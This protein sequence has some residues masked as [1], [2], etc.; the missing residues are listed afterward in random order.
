MAGVVDT[1]LRHFQHNDFNYTLNP[2]PLGDESIDDFLFKT[3]KGY[4]EHYA[5]AFAVLMRTAGMP[6]RV[7]TG[8]QG[9]SANPVDGYWVVRQADAHAWVEVWLSERG[10][11]RVDPTAAIAPSRV[12]EGIAAAIPQTE[13]LPGVVRGGID[14]LR[15]AR[16]QWE[17]L[18]NGWN[19]W[20]L[21]YD[22]ARQ[23]DLLGRL[24]ISTRWQ[25]LI[26]TLVVA[27]AIAVIVLA[28]WAMRRE[29]QRDPAVRLWLAFTRHM[30]RRGSAREP[31][32]GP[33]DYARRLGQRFPDLAEP[34]TRFCTAYARSQYG[35]AT[36]EDLLTM[37]RTLKL[38]RGL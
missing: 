1:A 29:R 5:S 22:Q 37:T 7:V 9:G 27:A 17:A 26:G 13:S 33:Y 3:R 28:L 15:Q 18:N 21:G 38:I 14:W 8:Y 2:P 23:T 11:V 31:W 35:N 10:W 24:G 30:A 12:E 19:Q 32:E 34:S 4:C 16:Y 20:V 25:S 36:D 6:A